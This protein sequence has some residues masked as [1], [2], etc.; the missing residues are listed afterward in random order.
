MEVVRCKLRDG[1][2]TFEIILE[3][4]V[5]REHLTDKNGVVVVD[6]AADE[7]GDK[8]RRKKRRKSKSKRPPSSEVDASSDGDMHSAASG[9]GSE[10]QLSEG[11]GSR[12]PNSFKESLLTVL[13]KLV[14]KKDDK[15]RTATPRSGSQL[16]GFLP[17]G[18][19]L[20]LLVRSLL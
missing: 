2:E 18:E 10:Q 5:E 15:Y 4:V 16:R 20:T 9:R 12:R 11:G 7:K 8:K 19:S 6:V 17:I 13:G 1:P 3:D 14:W